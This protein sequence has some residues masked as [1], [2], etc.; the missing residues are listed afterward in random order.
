MQVAALKTDD[1]PFTGKHA[2]VTGAGRGIG[3]DR[4]GPRIPRYRPCIVDQSVTA[5]E[6]TCAKIRALGRV[7][8]AIGGDTSDATIIRADPVSSGRPALWPD[9]FPR[10]QCRHIP[11]KS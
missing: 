10:Q 5:C 11:K 1:L 3:R 2:I 8:C 7:A 9:R 4:A 6:D